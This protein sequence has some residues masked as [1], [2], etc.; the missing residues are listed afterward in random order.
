MEGFNLNNAPK[1][2]N[3]Q[4]EL[5]FLRAHIAEKEK[6]LIDQGK[7]INK[8]KLAHDVI[9]EYRKFE[10]EDVLHKS[11]VMRKKEVEGRDTGFNC[12]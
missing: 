11:A 4:E 9:H 12:C 7:E 6:A 3:A 8:E 1:F 10:P 5:E 2:K